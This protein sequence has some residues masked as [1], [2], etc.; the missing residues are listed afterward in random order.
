MQPTESAIE[1]NPRAFEVFTY[2]YK[3]VLYLQ[4]TQHKFHTAIGAIE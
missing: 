2:V 3:D 4:S 1:T